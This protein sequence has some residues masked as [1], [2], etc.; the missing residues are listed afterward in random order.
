MKRIADLRSNHVMNT[1]GMPGG[2]FRL[3][4]KRMLCHPILCHPIAKMACAVLLLCA[5][6]VIAA[7]AQT[8]SSV[9]SFNGTDGQTPMSEALVQGLDGDLYGTTEFGGAYNG[10][11]VFKITS[12]GTLTSLWNFCKVSGCPDGDRP[13]AGMILVVGGNFY[14]TTSAGG[15]HGYGSVFRMTPAGV[16]TTIYSFCSL[17]GCADG[18]APNSVVQGADGNLYGTTVHGGTGGCGGCHGGGVFFKLTTA[19]VL[20]VLHNFCTGT[21]ADGNNPSAGVVQG[22]D[23][24]FYGTAIS[25][26]T[27]GA[28]TVF[29][30]TAAGVV[31]TLYAFCQL[32]T[33]TDGINP[34]APLVQGTDGNF[35]GTTDGDDSN[36]GNVF[37][38]TPAG[39]FTN[40][41][42]FGTDN[43]GGVPLAGLVQGNDGN[44]YG[45]TF[46]AFHDANCCGTIF[47]ITPAGVL[48]TL[49]TFDGTDGNGPYQLVQDT[50]GSFF[51][52]TYN[53]G[54]KNLGT[55][56]RLGDGRAAFVRVVTNQGKVGKT[57]DILGQGLTG[58]TGV[59][60]DGVAATFKIA[61]DTYLTATVPTGALTGTVTVTTFSSSFKSIQAFRVTPQFTSFSPSSGQVGSTVTITGVSLKQTSKVTIG[62]KPAT[63]TVESDTQVKATV[64]AGAKT[65]LKI[66]VTT[67]GGTASSTTAFAVV[68]LVKSFTPTSGPVGTSVTITGNSFTGAT[69]VTFGG[70]A[71]SSH[72][73]ISDTQIDALVPSGA[74][75]GTIAV[76]TPG[77][78]GSS[79]T[80]FT[81]TK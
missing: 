20:T 26:G 13:T 79:S 6:T 75:T 43:D 14:G 52:V 4:A 58:A 45:T 41:H 55:V 67:L 78:T 65:G 42:D 15:T 76:T 32:T 38:I 44:F 77:G 29:K 22:T 54:A 30:L 53:G 51:G 35:Y 40:L 62:G 8:F 10:G 33:C 28:G 2:A 49:H 47:K 24:N 50:G 61:S 81:V 46:T 36:Q 66:I 5:A 48:T 80:K 72:E 17:S 64:P 69:E 70:V 39:K 16:L 25:G 71:A 74:V 60:F 3:A 56:F 34:A 27:T 31:T 18:I 63:F 73:V 37:K 12:S 21:C 19:G 11:T 23:G 7:P 59:S 1:N 68:P 9:S 57:L